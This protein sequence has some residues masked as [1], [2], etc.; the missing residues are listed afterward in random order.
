MKNEQIQQII[1]FLDGGEKFQALLLEELKNPSLEDYERRTY[2]SLLDALLG[3][4]ELYCSMDEEEENTLTFQQTTT[5]QAQELLKGG[6]LYL[7]NQTYQAENENVQSG[8]DLAF[9][10]E[11]IGG[12]FKF[13]NLLIKTDGTVHISKEY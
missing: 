12:D 3:A 4:T 1:D 5:E 9:R 7:L 2:T 10:Y 8:I 6:S 11:T 13:R